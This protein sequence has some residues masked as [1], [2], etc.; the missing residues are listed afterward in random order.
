MPRLNGAALD[1]FRGGGKRDRR[2]GGEIVDGGDGPRA[3]SAYRHAVG[4]VARPACAAEDAARP[5][6]RA[7]A[8][9]CAVSTAPLGGLGDALEEEVEPRLPVAVACARA[10][11]SS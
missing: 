10:S 5:R 4:W 8:S 9:R 1:R 3:K 6:G 11:S 2:A 7:R